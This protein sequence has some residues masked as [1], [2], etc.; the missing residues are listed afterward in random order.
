[1][2]LKRWLPRTAITPAIALASLAH[3]QGPL[4]QGASSP[5]PQPTPAAQQNPAAPPAPKPEQSI[6]DRERPAP[7][8]DIE[9][10]RFRGIF[11][12]IGD[13]G[14]EFTDHLKS[15]DG[16]RVRIAGYMT[17]VCACKAGQCKHVPGRLLL[18]P[19][20]VI[21]DDA[22]MTYCDDLAPST[23]FVT[24]P[25]F[26]RQPVPFVAGPLLLTG[27]LSLGRKEEPDGRVSWIRLQLDPPEE[28]S[29]PFTSQPVP[30]ASSAA[31]T[32]TVSPVPSAPALSFTPQG[33]QK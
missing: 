23:I 14:L 18:G 27:T 2:R 10:L 25:Q 5:P 8:P 13:Y 17:R 22:E 33:E 11:K 7:K 6:D 28:T 31:P 29:T 12:P 30:P 1:M 24:V 21:L 32:T 19:R 26:K 16:K 3:A 20:P 4:E 9:D 15:L